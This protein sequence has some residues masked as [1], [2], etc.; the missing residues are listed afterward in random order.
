M[1][2]K[3][4]YE[5]SKENEL[6][7]FSDPQLMT[8]VALCVSMFLAPQLSLQGYPLPPLISRQ[9]VS[10]PTTAIARLIDSDHYEHR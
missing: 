10:H 7:W 6:R 8:G 3:Q 4:A 1:Q 5:C 2:Y 9:S